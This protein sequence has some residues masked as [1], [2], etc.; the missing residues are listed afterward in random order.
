MV[1][2]IVEFILELQIHNASSIVTTLNQSLIERNFVSS[3]YNGSFSKVSS[4][5][6]LENAFRLFPMVLF[7]D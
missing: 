7:T 6:E 2:F 1:I 3:H 4:M 5:G